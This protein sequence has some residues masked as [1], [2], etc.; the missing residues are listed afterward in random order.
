[1]QALLSKFQGFTAFALLAASALATPACDGAFDTS[2]PPPPVA[3]PAP[4]D[5][6]CAPVPAYGL[7]P[8]RDAAQRPVA[9]ERFVG[10]A[11]LTATWT[12]A[13][14]E[15]RVE[16]AL[17]GA[18]YETQRWTFGPAEAASG[19]TA[20]RLIERSVTRD[21][22]LAARVVDTLD[23][24]AV[25]P[26]EDWSRALPAERH[27]RGTTCLRLP[28]SFGH[29]YPAAEGWYRPGAADPDAPE[30]MGSPRDWYGH[31]GDG[32]GLAEGTLAVTLRYDARGRMIAED[33]EREEGLHD[34]QRRR[35]FD[36]ET[37]VQDRLE[38]FSPTPKE[39][40]VRELRFAL[41]NPS[42]AGSR[43]RRDLLDTWET[44]LDRRYLSGTA[45]R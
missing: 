30:P 37:L 25:L 26:S 23:D 36:G 43:L 22:A 4:L 20:L 32:S 5:D 31:E 6:W 21:P 17:D 1:M 41:T 24:L 18:T 7:V 40:T 13:P 11:H 39:D 2:D 28:S 29:G 15:L 42:D 38:R 14:T 45:P 3:L 10:P 44:L 19:A 12:Y 16:R 27:T 35:V 33:L 9:L 8:T 34:V